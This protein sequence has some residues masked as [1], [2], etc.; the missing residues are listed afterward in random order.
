MICGFVQLTLENLQEQR[1]HHLSG[2]PVSLLFCY[3]FL[4]S[5]VCP[6]WTIQVVLCDVCNLLHC[7]LLLRQVWVY[8]SSCSLNNCRLLLDYLLATLTKP[9]CFNLPLWVAWL[10]YGVCITHEK[11]RLLVH[12][13]FGRHCDPQ[14]ISARLL[15]S[16]SVPNL[17][18]CLRHQTLHLC[19]M[20]WSFRCPSPPFIKVL[21]NWISQ[22]GD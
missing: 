17:Q 20:W 9:N 1:L 21:L 7:L 8:H 15:H 2:Q 22:E 10:L 6:I 13:Q 12:I 14:V 5:H 19:W 4:F 11:S 16:P 18:W 3:W